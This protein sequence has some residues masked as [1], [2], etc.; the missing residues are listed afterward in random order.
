MTGCPSLFK[1]KIDLDLRGGLEG[2]PP[3][4]FMKAEA[5]WATMPMHPSSSVFFC[6]FL[7]WKKKSLNPVDFVSQAAGLMG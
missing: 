6:Y 2:P 7:R 3:S 5:Y 1:K 4:F